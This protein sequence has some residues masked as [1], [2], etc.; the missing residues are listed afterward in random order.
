M[1]KEFNITGSC[2]LQWHYMVDTEQRF[3]A[4]E[5]LIDRGKYF[6]I[7]RARQYGKTT[8]L[9]M[10]WRRLSDKY[11]IIDT[12]LE[13]VGDTAFGSEALFVQLVVTLMK[14]ALKNANGPQRDV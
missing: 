4:I 6:A 9:R 7:N 3:K 10:I 14:D 12:S 5:N 11:L 8:T 1:R 2:N 13:G